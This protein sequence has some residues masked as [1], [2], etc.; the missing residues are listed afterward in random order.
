MTGRQKIRAAA[1]VALMLMATLAINAQNTGKK[2]VNWRDAR[3]TNV[4]VFMTDVEM[5]VSEDFNTHKTDTTIT[6]NSR[7]V[8][9]SEGADIMDIKKNDFYKQ[10]ERVELTTT[11]GDAHADSVL[12]SEM[13]SVFRSSGTIQSGTY[14]DALF[15]K[16]YYYVFTFEYPS[17]DA[18]GNPVTLSGIAACPV[19]SIA[20][21]VNN[22]VLGTHITITSDRE[23]PS[24]RV[25]GFGLDDWG[26]LMSLAADNKMNYGGLNAF[27]KTGIMD[28]LT[29]A[30]GGLLTP[31]YISNMVQTFKNM[32][33]N[34]NYNNC[35]VVMPDYEGYG[36]TK[37]HAHP[38][39]Y[40]ELTARQSVDALMYAKALYESDPEL[41]DI[42]L[43]IRSNFRTMSCGY[44]QGGSVAMACH[45][46]IEQNGLAKE[47][48]FTGSACGDGP[49]DPVA[50]LMYYVKQSE[51]GHNMNMAVVL[52]LIMKGMLDCNPY[53]TDHKAEDYFNQKF[54]DTGIMDWLASKDYSTTDIGKKFL[55]CLEEGRDGDADYY[56][57]LFV[58]VVSEYDD[59]G[60]PKYAG[61]AK[62]SN[63]MKPEVY[64]YFK[65]LYD[66]NKNTYTSAAGIPLPTKRGVLED[67]HLALASNDLTRGW[68]PS[69]YIL[70]FNSKDDPVVPY[71]NALRVMNSV[72]EE[73]R[74]LMTRSGLDHGEGG[75]A[76]FSRDSKIGIVV[77]EKMIF[78]E[79]IDELAKNNY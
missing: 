19:P 51:A 36:T 38:Y 56:K 24:S 3:V 39:L 18:Q 37:D 22:I 11:T 7:F 14:Q 52:P 49:Y 40:Q 31:L 50:T 58:K 66:N 44:S 68:T 47:L 34:T 10:G 27:T 8:W 76:F 2:L 32:N 15:Q 72:S 46:F 21:R 30:T 35:L 64:Q 4:G 75:K 28:L 16:F 63:I 45:R 73:H 77:F 60:N 65:T 26:M 6:D 17:I 9:K 42:R 33:S 53:M 57:D 67:L 25:N 70:M 71:D 29:L 78:F 5:K 13:K 20:S 23:R 62:L 1:F 12:Q 43:P 59:N 55:K 61:T 54:L 69:G 48:H 79:F 41:E 74:D